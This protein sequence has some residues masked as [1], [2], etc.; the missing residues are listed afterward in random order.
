ME[1]PIKFFIAIMILAAASFL[2]Y[3]LYVNYN[4]SR[5]GEERGLKENDD[6]RLFEGGLENM[7]G[8]GPE[9][10]QYWYRDPQ[11]DLPYKSIPIWFDVENT[12]KKREEN[13]EVV[14]KRNGDVVHTEVRDFAPGLY[15]RTFT[16]TF[17][18]DSSKV[19]SIT[20]WQNGKQVVNGDSLIIR[21]RLPREMPIIEDPQI[22]QLY[23]TPRYVEVIEAKDQIVANA[24]NHWIAIRDW[25]ESNIVY[26]NDTRKDRWQ[27]SHETLDQ[28][29]GDSEDIAILL[30]SLLR[31]DG[32]AENEV[33][34][35]WGLT[36]DVSRAWCVL[37]TLNGE[38]VWVKLE[39]KAS[40]ILTEE[41]DSFEALMETILAEVME[42]YV[43]NDLFIEK[44]S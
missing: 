2:S 36:G 29:Q 24:S 13:V 7:I 44:Y 35:V 23:I 33:Y 30:C 32:W 10:E 15:T 14:I 17:Q 38:G 3:F 22:A 9:R 26:V 21:A 20:L 31:A 6:M 37:K 42:A 34:V 39:P 4:I 12:G 11:T 25:V 28:M 5:I 8:D 43:F 19:M 41:F 27:L 40:G 1:R 16:L 18:Y